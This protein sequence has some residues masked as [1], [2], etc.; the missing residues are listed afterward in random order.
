MGDAGAL[1]L[2]I[3]LAALTI[4]FNE[5]NIAVAS[6][7]HVINAPMVS[8]CILVLPMFDTIR[9]F[10]IRIFN[11]K[12]PFAPDKN[13]LHHMFLALG[14]N[15]KQA[16]GIL[17]LINVIYVVIGLLCQNIPKFFFFIIIL[18]SCVLWS[19]IL[20]TLIKSREKIKEERCNEEI[21]L[22]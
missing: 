14:C 5:V 11:K 22:D 4:S 20:R 1:V 21:V 9:V 15:H 3:V 12:S 17:L 19:E 18:L 16:T 6:P 2:G 10:T 7:Y 13:H 8:I